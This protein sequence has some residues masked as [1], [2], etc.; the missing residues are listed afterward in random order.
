MDNLLRW[1]SFSGPYNHTC[2][3]YPNCIPC[4]LVCGGLY[5]RKQDYFTSLLED[6]QGNSFPI[7][8]VTILSIFLGLYL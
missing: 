5:Y 3:R 4:Q 8:S 7:D 1:C 6:A 2:A